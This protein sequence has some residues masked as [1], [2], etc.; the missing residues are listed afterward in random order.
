MIAHAPMTWNSAT[1][2]PTPRIRKKLRT[3][4]SPFN[5]LSMSPVRR[6]WKNVTGS[7]SKVSATR[8]RLA[9]SIRRAALV[10][11]YRCSTVSRAASPRTPS[12]TSITET[13]CPVSRRRITFSIT[14]LLENGIARV[15]A[16][17]PI[18]QRVAST[19]A[20][21]SAF[22]NGR[23]KAPPEEATGV[24]KS[25]SVGAVNRANPVKRSSN[26]ARSSTPDVPTGS[27]TRTSRLRTSSST[28]Q[29][30]PSTWHSAG[31][32]SSSS[33]EVDTV[34]IAA[35]SPSRSAPR[36]RPSRLVPSE[37]VDTASRTA[38]MLT[39]WP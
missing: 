9:R 8:S 15:E 29:W 36:C 38:T 10:M 22:R 30:L 11:T 20:G 6:F 16:A 28:T 25:A 32:G 3:S 2:A 12:T 27:I 37:A 19:I 31:S 4:R 21:H 18:P 5:R 34:V 39:W 17:M 23:K 14:H 33:R 35:V 26:S 7:A 1:K 13:S 24:S